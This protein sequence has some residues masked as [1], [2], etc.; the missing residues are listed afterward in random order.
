MRDRDHVCSVLDASAC[1]EII[2]LE[3][4]ESNMVSIACFRLDADEK[5]GK[6]TRH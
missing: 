2:W 6:D 5:I 3:D 4:G 1:Q